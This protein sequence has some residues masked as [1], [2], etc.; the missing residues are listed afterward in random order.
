MEVS[1]QND[2][3]AALFPGKKPRAALTRACVGSITGQKL[4]EKKKIYLDLPG[5]KTWS[6][7]PA[8]KLL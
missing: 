1:G 8:E 3:R 6:V 4:L 5:Y 7:R 2:A